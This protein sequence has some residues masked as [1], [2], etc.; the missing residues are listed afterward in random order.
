MFY[1]ECW[2]HPEAGWIAI[3]EPPPPLRGPTCSS[4]E[5]YPA[6]YAEEQ[7]QTLEGLIADARDQN[8]ADEATKDE[9]VVVMAEIGEGRF[10]GVDPLG[11]GY[12]QSALGGVLG[13]QVLV[14]DLIADS[15]GRQQDIKVWEK[16]IACFERSL[17]T[18]SPYGYTDF[19]GDLIQFQFSSFDFF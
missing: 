17:P 9:L 14:L 7:I 18:E 16:R 15:Q 11:P 3:P 10:D 12:T 1:Y 2:V 19:P 6:S 13:N 4:D 5:R 8:E